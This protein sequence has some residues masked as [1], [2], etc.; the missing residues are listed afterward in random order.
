MLC[1]LVEALSARGIGSKCCAGPPAAPGR[2]WPRHG[3][4]AGAE[5]V[6]KAGTSAGDSAVAK[7]EA[8]SGGGGGGGGLVRV[9]ELP[10]PYSSGVVVPIWATMSACAW[11]VIGI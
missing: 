6:S 1:S 9:L 8:Q 11:F 4:L 10:Q 2:L 7:A 5:A 3:A